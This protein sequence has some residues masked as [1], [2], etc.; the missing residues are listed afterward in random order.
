MTATESFVNCKL[1]REIPLAI[2]KYF[3]KNRQKF[4]LVSLAQ[5]V[6]L[7]RPDIALESPMSYGSELEYMGRDLCPILDIVHP[8]G[9]WPIRSLLYLRR[10]GLFDMQFPWPH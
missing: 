10:C 7:A 4:P 8:R 6:F 2:S 9:F 5:R 3:L 1:D